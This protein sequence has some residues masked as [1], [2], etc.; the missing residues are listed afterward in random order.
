MIIGL[1]LVL[2]DQPK[3]DAILSLVGGFALANPDYQTLL[4]EIFIGQMLIVVGIVIMIPAIILKKKE[5]EPKEDIQY[6][7]QPEW[8]LRKSPILKGVI[9]GIILI[10]IFWGIFGLVGYQ[11]FS[12][13]NDALSPDVMKGDLMHY[14]RIP[15]N[16][17]KVDDIIA[18]IPSAKD[19]IGAKVGKVRIIDSG[20]YVQ[21]S[22]N[23]NPNT[24]SQVYEKDYVGKIISITSQGGGIMTVYSAPYHLVITAVLFVIPIVIMKIRELENSKS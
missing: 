3:A 17:I 12:M 18:F 23:A 19:E 1:A 2:Y 9:I 13:A 14:Q 20:N 6:K 4:R 15:F 22:S 11:T 7:V 5:A 10:V 21:T 16:E 8:N 24:L